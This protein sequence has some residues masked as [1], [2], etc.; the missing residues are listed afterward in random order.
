MNKGLFTYHVDF[1]DCVVERRVFDFLLI[2]QLLRYLF[3]LFLLSIVLWV[4]MIIVISL[5]LLMHPLTIYLNI[6][7]SFFNKPIQLNQS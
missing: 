7:Y 5:T 4:A 3:H 2:V 6:I 1:S